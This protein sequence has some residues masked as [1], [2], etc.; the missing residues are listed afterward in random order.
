MA[1]VATLATV[2]FQL[3][4]LV[5]GLDRYLPV[6]AVNLVFLGAYAAVPTLNRAGRGGA[7][8]VVVVA[9]IAGQLFGATALVGA[10]S[11][12]HLFYFSLAIL[13][14]LLFPSVRP[15]LP[16][17]WMTVA[18]GLYLACE[19]WFPSGR[20]PVEVPARVL[21]WMFAGSAIGTVL[22]GGLC[23]LAFK[24]EV[25]RAH[26]ELAK[27]NAELER[28]ARVDAL[29]GVANRRALD[30]RLVE[31]WRRLERSGGS[32]SVLL[33]DIDR[34]KAFND[35]YGHLAGD[36]QLKQVAALLTSVVRRATD[37]V[38]RYGG[39]EFAMVL[40]GTDLD[41]AV[42]LAEAARARVEDAGRRPAPG[43]QADTP[44]ISVG[45]AHAV[46][47]GLDTPGTLL[48]R[49]D[50]ALYE[51]KRAGRNRVVAWRMPA[52]DGRLTTTG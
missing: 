7:A 38:A 51:A 13:L 19:M 1:S 47:G 34:F 52:A 50:A 21:D 11:G 40:P 49:A 4:Y 17:A 28:L 22:S 48:E 29:T 32:L 44:T 42:E 46:P 20:A 14:F 37:L 18:V 8:R 31:E 5:A 3:Y 12:I 33:C 6:F 36:A 10:D 26:A 30:E 41:T 25:G 16:L 23:S 24:S 43:S 27:S 39:E 9:G 15:A 2:P 45:V 35:R